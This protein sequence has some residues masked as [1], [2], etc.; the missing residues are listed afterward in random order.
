MLQ[1]DFVTR[2]VTFL[3]QVKI[4]HVAVVIL[5]FVNLK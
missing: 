5:S 4:I 1:N 3:A 2:D